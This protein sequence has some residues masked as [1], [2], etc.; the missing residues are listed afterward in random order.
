MTTRSLVTTQD[1]RVTT[2]ARR[3]ILQ[4]DDMRYQAAKTFCLSITP[5]GKSKTLFPAYALFCR[6]TMLQ[7]SVPYLGDCNWTL[8]HYC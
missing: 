1:K 3:Q 7:R 6:P 2:L 8:Q 4:R 5:I